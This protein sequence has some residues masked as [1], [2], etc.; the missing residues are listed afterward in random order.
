MSTNEPTGSPPA[1]PPPPPAGSAPLDALAQA[2]VAVGAT[3]ARTQKVARL[4]ALLRSLSDHELPLAVHYL[5][6]SAPQGKLGVGYA[7]V[8]R[9]T[10]S[11]PATTPS[12]TLAEV[13]A[14]LTTMATALAAERG[15]WLTTDL[16]LLHILLDD[17]EVAEALNAV[18]ADLE[19][20]RRRVRMRLTFRIVHAPVS[21]PT[22]SSSWRTG[23]ASR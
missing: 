10:E 6:G 15:D 11:A 19:A 14:A 16:D 23:R 21:T 22:A 4:A 2:S 7:L 13:D 5:T 9:A 1:P 8:S 3:R 17:D 20:L 18:P 12:L